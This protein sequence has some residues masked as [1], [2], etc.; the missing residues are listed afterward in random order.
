MPKPLKWFLW[1]L[2]GVGIVRG[3]IHFNDA[4]D[5]NVL[6]RFVAAIVGIVEDFTYRWIG[7]IVGWFSAD[8]REWINTAVPDFF[9]ALTGGS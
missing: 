3:V 5:T 4:N 1:A 8:G 9:T 6:G 7:V 2:V